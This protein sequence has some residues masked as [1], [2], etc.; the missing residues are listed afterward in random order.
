MDMGSE[1]PIEHTCEHVYLPFTKY[2]KHFS[3]TEKQMSTFVAPIQ[4]LRGVFFFQTLHSSY[5]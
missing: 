3:S 5:P 2:L 1:L 4:G